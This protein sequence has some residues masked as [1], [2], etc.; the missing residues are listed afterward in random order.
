MVDKIICELS[1]LKLL[2]LPPFHLENMCFEC[3]DLASSPEELAAEISFLK[4]PG[5]D[6]ICC[7]ISAV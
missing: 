7:R 1:S 5:K 6:R 3:K 4:P 2:S